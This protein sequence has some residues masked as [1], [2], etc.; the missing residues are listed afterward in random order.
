MWGGCQETS[1]H[2]CFESGQLWAAGACLVLACG[3]RSPPWLFHMGKP[4][5]SHP[6]CCS[7]TVRATAWRGCPQVCTSFW[8]SILADGVTTRLIPLWALC[9]HGGAVV[10]RQDRAGQE[11][12]ASGHGRSLVIPSFYNIR[13]VYV[14]STGFIYL[15]ILAVGEG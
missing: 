15:P 4:K 12:S 13:K 5:H 9:M 3:S 7:Q 6:G 10:M 8:N 2:R 14:R 1:D 11:Y